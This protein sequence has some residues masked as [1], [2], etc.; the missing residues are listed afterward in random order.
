MVVE[1]AVGRAA[2]RKRIVRMDYDDLDLLPEDCWFTINF[3]SDARHAP[4]EYVV[5]EWWSKRA[6]RMRDRTYLHR[7]IMGLEKGNPLTVDH[8]DRD[9][10]N[11]RRS[12]LR[13]ATQSQNSQNTTGR[14]RSWAKHGVWSRHRGVTWD[15][16][17]KRW[18]ATVC[19]DR[20]QHHL[21]HFDDEEQAAAVCRAFRAEHMP[22]A[23]N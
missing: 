21:G 17:K 3:T 10:L 14:S 16:Q 7:I 12:N 23:L 20:R 6:T 22:Y 2:R 8:R 9:P 1:I 4:K 13:I 15:D 11:N 5:V 19:L 18:R